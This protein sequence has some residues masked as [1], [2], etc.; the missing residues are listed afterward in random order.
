MDHPRRGDDF[1]DP[2]TQRPPSPVSSLGS[3]SGSSSGS[4]LSDWSRLSALSQPPRQPPPVYS[5]PRTGPPSYSSDR[6]SSGRIAF[7]PSL[8]SP[9]E[10]DDD[11]RAI[12]SIYYDD[13]KK[14]DTKSW[15]NDK[16][17]PL[18]DKKPAVLH[19]KPTLLPLDAE[20]LPGLGTPRQRKRRRLACF[21][22]GFC[23]MSNSA[24]CITAGVICLVVLIAAIV[25][26]TVI[27]SSKP[28]PASPN[29][30][31]TTV[32]TATVTQTPTTPPTVTVTGISTPTSTP[33]EAWALGGFDSLA[34]SIFYSDR[35]GNVVHIFSNG[36]V[37]NNATPFIVGRGAVAGSP[38]QAILDPHSQTHVVYISSSG[39]LRGVTAPYTGYSYSTTS[40]TWY[41]SAVNVSGLVPAAVNGSFLRMYD[42]PQSTV[43][44][45]ETATGTPMS[46]VATLMFRGTDGIIKRYGARNSPYNSQTGMYSLQWFVLDEAVPF[47]SG[48]TM[49]ESTYDAAGEGIDRVV[50]D[51][52]RHT[53]EQR[54]TPHPQTNLLAFTSGEQVTLGRQHLMYLDETGALVRADL[55]GL[56]SN[57]TVSLSE[58]LTSGATGGT[59]LATDSSSGNCGETFVDRLSYLGT[60]TVTTSVV[61][62]KL[63]IVVTWGDPVDPAPQSTSNS[64]SGDS[65]D[66]WG[67]KIGAIVGAV[68][69]FLVVWGI[70][71]M[72]CD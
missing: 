51:D 12:S 22:F 19:K 68:F 24:C 21:G 32:V 35:S 46:V 55:T 59:R 43:Y 37:W 60:Y 15:P 10:S 38:V 30:T 50:I 57:V 33:T 42:V 71:A 20:P 52:D 17:R 27:L 23:W 64:G 28:M 49:A 39:E 58:I 40:Q 29:S 34:G 63:P 67:K 4:P 45:Y 5:P 7:A 72:C 70:G 61:D 2:P 65:G 47:L 8:P 25:P 6:S 3:G 56:G 11:I 1:Q 41:D 69:G 66:S 36:Y 14:P 9:R 13:L 16:E 18:P 48:A 53:V 26:P 62:V 54:Q 31:A 44:Y